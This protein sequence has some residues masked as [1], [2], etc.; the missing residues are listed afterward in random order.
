MTT[1]SLLRLSLPYENPKDDVVSPPKASTSSP[2][3]HTPI[4]MT[5]PSQARPSQS[6]TTSSSPSGPMTL[7]TAAC[8][9]YDKAVIRA[10][11]RKGRNNS[12]DA[13]CKELFDHAELLFKALIRKHN[14]D[15]GA[16]DDS[17]RAAMMSNAILGDLYAYKSSS[18]GYKEDFPLAIEYYERAVQL[19]TQTFEGDVVTKYSSTLHWI[20]RF[21][22]A[23]K[24]NDRFLDDTL[25]HPHNRSRAR[26]F[27]NKA[28][29]YYFWAMHTGKNVHETNAHWASAL[30]NALMAELHQHID[31]DTKLDRNDSLQLL[32]YVKAAAAHFKVTPPII[33]TSKSTKLSRTKGVR[34]LVTK[35]IADWAAQL[36][37]IFTVDQRTALQLLS[38]NAG[39]SP[40]KRLRTDLIPS[41]TDGGKINDMSFT[42]ADTSTE[43][44]AEAD[45]EPQRKR[46][47]SLSI[48]ATESTSEEDV[49]STQSPMVN[50]VGQRPAQGSFHKALR[51]L[52]DDDD[53]LSSMPDNLA[54][55]S[56]D[57]Q[58]YS[59]QQIAQLNDFIQ[60]I[61]QLQHT[62]SNIIVAQD[63]ARTS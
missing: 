57:F 19:M 60:R 11:A 23:I 34:R 30:Y 9:V 46:M 5:Q 21:D 41:S 26:L 40:Q 4:E 37:T 42:S 49:S 1:R 17:R 36:T 8:S 63:N 61:D 33:S 3:M 45:D 25:L 44:D 28:E 62:V 56:R 38:A 18:L 7:F 54:E 43:G 10:S 12:A 32:D 48:A 2:V 29:A 20:K 55:L 53:V 24:L 15:V 52:K 58:R 47:R 39:F 51:F 16:D 13:K 59:N 14:G 27:L 22:D 35:S 31:G 6:V 50:A